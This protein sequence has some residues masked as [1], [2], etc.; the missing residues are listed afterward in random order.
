MSPTS[1]V[2]YSIRFFVLLFFQVLIL[3]QMSMGWGDVVYWNIMLYPLFVLWMPVRTSTWLLLL[4]GFAMGLLVD[5]FYDSPGVHA[6]A[7]VLTAFVRPLALRWMEPREGYSLNAYPSRSVFGFSGFMRYAALLMG[8]HLFVYFSVEAFTFVYLVDILQKT[9]FSFLF[10][11][12]FIAMIT[13][14]FSSS[15]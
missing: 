6:S 2:T 11:M 3:K 10:S 9:F 7:L 12:T 15:K 5:I 13:L 14:I 1:V 4:L 8:L